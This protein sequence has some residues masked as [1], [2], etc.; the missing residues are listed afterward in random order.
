[1]GLL[2]ALTP[3]DLTGGVKVAATGTMSPTGDVGEIGGLKQKT[4]AVMRTGAKVFLVPESEKADAEAAAKG[5]DLKIVGVTT[6]DD[7][8]KELASLGGNALDLG[9]PGAAFQPAA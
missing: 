8:L 3:G 5:S 4:I 7:A 9:Q 2:D 1:L 6:L